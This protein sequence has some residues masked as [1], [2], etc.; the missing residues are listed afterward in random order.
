MYPVW[1]LVLIVYVSSLPSLLE[2]VVV[3]F[4]DVAVM[5]EGVLYGVAGI[6][7]VINSDAIADAIA[8]R[9]IDANVA[10]VPLPCQLTQ[11]TPHCNCLLNNLQ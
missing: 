2:A 10:S 4:G 3:L 11:V 1:N 6:D 9:A 7:V 5:N 8:M